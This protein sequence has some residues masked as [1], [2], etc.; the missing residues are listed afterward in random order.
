M[1][2]TGPIDGAVASTPG[3]RMKVAVICPWYYRGDAVGAAAR[4]TFLHLAAAPDLDV[5]ALWTVND[6]DDVSGHR[7][8][9]VADLLLDPIFLEADLLIYV[10]AVY[11]PFFDALL[12]GNGHAK[13]VVRF[14]NV[15][16][17][18][19]M[20]AK[21]RAVIERSFV[22]MSN[23]GRADEIWCESRENL[24]E[25]ER[26]GQASR[27]RIMPPSVA[28][29][30]RAALADKTAEKVELM[31]VGRFFESK[32]ILD[33]VDAAAAMRA[34]GETEFRIRL[35]GNLRFSDPDY[36]DLVRNRIADLRLEGLVDL[37]GS[38]EPEGLAT[39]FA[40][41]HVFLSGSRHEGFCVPVIEGLA[42]GC[43]PVTYANSNLRFVADGLGRL[44]HE[45][46]SQGLAGETLEV[47]KGLR[48]AGRG[49]TIALDRGRM[50]L[51]AFDAAARAYVEIFEPVRYGERVLTR[52]HDLLD[53]TT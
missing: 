20:P 40:E 50:T 19:L 5:K 7:A 36:V 48:I 22:Q 11:H 14:H 46:T 52:T 53:G 47:I 15:T 39:A 3:A 42:A 44:A 17:A 8:E 26:R 51:E 21:H 25:L 35:F 18:A 38:V 9:T 33:V 4:E 24:E 1:T 27:A 31:Y 41:S 12:V 23:F 30:V 45:Q 34:A 43:V 28:I 13:Q 2:E 10:F 49:G 32:G 29:P 37:V 16:P 6:Y